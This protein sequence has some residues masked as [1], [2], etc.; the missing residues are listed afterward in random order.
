MDATKTNEDIIEWVR[1]FLWHFQDS[2]MSED[3]AAKIIC[4]Y[5]VSKVDIRRAL[6]TIKEANGLLVKAQIARVEAETKK[7]EAEIELVKAQTEMVKNQSPLI[8]PRN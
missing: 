5:V 3:K 2:P 8:D 6:M 4:E 7:I 1:K